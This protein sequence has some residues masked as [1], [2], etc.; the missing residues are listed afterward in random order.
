[1]MLAVMRLDT[2]ARQDHFVVPLIGINYCRPYTSM[3]V[4]ARDDQ[5]VAMKTAEKIV[6][7]RTKESAVA[8]F[9]NDVV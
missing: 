6:K 9:Y 4:Y 3:R 2:L 5:R 1:M 8:L 7:I